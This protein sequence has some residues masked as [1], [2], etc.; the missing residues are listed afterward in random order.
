MP[1]SSFA[2]SLR[3]LLILGSDPL[4]DAGV[5]LSLAVL[6][7]G[8]LVLI[9]RTRAALIGKPA[10]K[11]V[12]MH[13]MVALLGVLGGCIAYLREISFSHRFLDLA[14]GG[15]SAVPWMT[16]VLLEMIRRPSRR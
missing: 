5:V 16:V 10:L 14:A 9:L 12:Q 2:S 1:V 13:R 11:S 7:G 8:V 15:F 3:D 4:R 6:L